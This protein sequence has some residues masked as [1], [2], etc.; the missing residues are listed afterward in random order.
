MALLSEVILR[1]QA[2]NYEEIEKRGSLEARK[3][4]GSISNK[5]ASSKRR[6]EAP[7]ERRLVQALNKVQ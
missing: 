3:R 7:E 2:P 1:K 5:V 4:A 6:Q